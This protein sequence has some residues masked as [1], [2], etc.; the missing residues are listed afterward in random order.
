MRVDDSRTYIFTFTV[1]GH[2]QEFFEVDQAENVAYFKH[3][4]FYNMYLS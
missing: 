3:M 4:F 1:G 2:K